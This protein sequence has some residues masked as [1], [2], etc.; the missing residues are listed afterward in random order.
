MRDT[1]F[2]YDFIEEFDAG[3]H[4]DAERDQVLRLLE[5]VVQEVK[6]LADKDAADLGCSVA[7]IDAAP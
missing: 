5:D 2:H 4:E 1:L 7:K 6:L 3:N